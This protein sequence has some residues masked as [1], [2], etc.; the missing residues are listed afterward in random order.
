M[1]VALVLAFLF[2]I[3]STFG[4]LLELFFRKCVAKK[5]INPGFLT[6]PYLPIYGFALWIL[7]GLSFIQQDLSYESHCARQK[8]IAFLIYSFPNVLTSI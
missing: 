1:N 2:Y 8:Y 5:W 4:W 7:F 6:G 3:G